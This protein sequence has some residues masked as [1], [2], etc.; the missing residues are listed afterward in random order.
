MLSV[1][2][3]EFYDSFESG[4]YLGLPSSISRNKKQVFGFLKNRMWKR[5]NSWSNRFLSIADR[6]V[7][8][9]SMVRVL[10]AYCMSVFKLPLCLYDE[11]EKMMNSF[12]WGS[13]EGEKKL[14]WLVWNHICVREK[15][16]GMGFRDL[17]NFNLAMLAKQGGVC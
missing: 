9:K 15:D 3:L 10:S 4:T 1:V 8:I 14:H 7:L 11:L 6:E 13:K 16:G 2:F 5:I 17:R 12:W